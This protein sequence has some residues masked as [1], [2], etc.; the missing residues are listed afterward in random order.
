MKKIEFP[1][2]DAGFSRLVAMRSRLPHAILLCGPPGLGKRRLAEHFAQSLM[3]ENAGN[4]GNP[5]GTCPACRWFEEGNH[6]DFRLVV[7]EILAIEAAMA[8]SGAEGTADD[9]AGAPKASRAPSKSIRID[10]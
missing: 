9:D 8:G 10:Q 1:W 6:P 3:C 5:C 4:D 7:P 2:L